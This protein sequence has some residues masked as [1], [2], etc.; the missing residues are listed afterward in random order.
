MSFVSQSAV[1]PSFVEP[2]LP[3]VQGFYVLFILTIDMLQNSDFSQT[4]ALMSL[5]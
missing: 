4:I 3:L 2:L 5:S 1:S